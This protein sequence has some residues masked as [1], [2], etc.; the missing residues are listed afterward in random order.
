MAPVSR[1]VDGDDGN[2]VNRCGWETMEG[3]TAAVRSFQR[4]EEKVFRLRFFFS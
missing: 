3:K 4:R 2:D 1:S